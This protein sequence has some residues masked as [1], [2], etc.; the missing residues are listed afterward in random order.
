[1]QRFVEALAA[2]ASLEAESTGDPALVVG[3]GYTTGKTPQELVQATLDAV[4]R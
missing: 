3:Q 2:A 4:T 1:M